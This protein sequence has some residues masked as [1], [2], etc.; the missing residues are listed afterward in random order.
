[1][2]YNE[3]VDIFSDLF[4]DVRGFRPRGG[5]MEAFIN[6]SEEDQLRELDFLSKENERQINDEISA[7]KRAKKVLD[8]RIADTMKLCNCDKDSAIRILMDADGAYTKDE[9]YWMN[10]I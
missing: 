8:Q 3:N 9:L 1:M 2:D 7:R 4:K 5:I 6:M 10:G